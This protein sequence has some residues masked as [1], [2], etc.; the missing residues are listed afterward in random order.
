L[1]EDMGKVIRSI[2]EA[3]EADGSG[4]KEP[5]PMELPDR[6]WRADPSD[7]LRPLS[8]VRKQWAKG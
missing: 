7:G 1:P 8:E 4:I 3:F 6:E 2:K 5:M